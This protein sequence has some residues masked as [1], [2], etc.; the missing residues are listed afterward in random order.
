VASLQSVNHEDPVRRRLGRLAEKAK[1]LD[2]VTVKSY[3]SKKTGE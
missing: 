3:A 1:L 2:A